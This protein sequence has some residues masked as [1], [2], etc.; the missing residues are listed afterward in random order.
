MTFSVEKKFSDLMN[1]PGIDIE[2]VTV[3]PKS[4]AISILK[5]RNTSNMHTGSYLMPITMRIHYPIV[6]DFGNSKLGLTSAPY[7]RHLELPISIISPWDSFSNSIRNSLQNFEVAINF[8]GAVAGGFV[9]ILFSR[10][11]FRSPSS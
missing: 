5:L 4:I 10:W 11:L 8:F 3:E 9:G 7:E 6:D 1:D 2:P